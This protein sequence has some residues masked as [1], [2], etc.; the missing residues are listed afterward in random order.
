MEIDIGTIKE[1]D[2]V[3]EKVR[4]ISIKANKLL[5]CNYNG[6]Y[7]LPGGKIDGDEDLETAL[8]R[9]IFEETGY[10]LST[11]NQFLTT[12]NYSDNYVSRNSS[13]PKKRK[14]K[15]TYYITDEDIDLNNKRKLSEEESN[16]RFTIKYMDIEDLVKVLE[17]SPINDKQKTF[18]AEVLTVLN[19]YLKNYS[20]IDL[21]THTTA[22]DGQYSP[23][24]VIE[25]AIKNQVN[26]IAITDHDT[27]LGLDGINYSDTRIKIIPGIE[28]TVKREKGRMHIVGLGIDYKNKDLIEFLE[29]MKEYNRHNLNNIINYLKDN[30]IYLK[31]DDIKAIFE[32]ETNIGR[33]DVA[34]LLIKEGYVKSVQEAFDKYLIEAFLKTRHLNF[35][36]TYKDVLDII[37]AANGISILAHPNSLELNHEEFEELIKDMIQNNLDGLEIYHSNMSQEEREYYMYIASKYQ[38]YISGGSDYHGEKVKPDIKLGTGKNNIYITDLPILKKLNNRTY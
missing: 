19:Y 15:T 12:N 13:I 3:V 5:V 35:G 4:L 38:L 31:E 26:T 10:N 23:N 20:I 32:K 21:H 22:S 29:N 7:M 28:M 1:Y 34:Q 17:T 25:Q 11:Y 30:N 33:P 18:A 16:G 8:R 9:E 2:E 6:Y 37:K 36:Y 24:E 14:I 27:V